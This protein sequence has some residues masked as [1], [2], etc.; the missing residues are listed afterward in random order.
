MLIF[1]MYTMRKKVILVLNKRPR[2][3]LDDA[4]ITTEAKYSVNITKLR[5]NVFSVYTTMQP[6]VFGMFKV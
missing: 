4:A 6:T 3:E 5:K 1:L 2:E